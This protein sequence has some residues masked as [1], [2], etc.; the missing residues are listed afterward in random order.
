MEPATDTRQVSLGSRE[1]WS[2]TGKDNPCVVWETVRVCQLDL[3]LH[4]PTTAFTAALAG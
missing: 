2:T 1:H 3:Q 4:K